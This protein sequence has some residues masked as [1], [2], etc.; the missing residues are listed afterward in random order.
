MEMFAKICFD[1]KKYLVHI[2]GKSV[3]FSVCSI[4]IIDM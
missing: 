4:K 2:E 3:C 1:I